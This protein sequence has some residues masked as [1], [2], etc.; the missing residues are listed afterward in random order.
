MCARSHKQVPNAG[1]LICMHLV[2]E[3][4]NQTNHANTKTREER[5]SITIKRVVASLQ[6]RA[7]LHGG[8]PTLHF[9][10]QFQ[11]MSFH[12]MD[13]YDIKKQKQIEAISTYMVILFLKT[14]SFGVCGFGKVIFY[15]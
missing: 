12:S 13:M 5:A 15:S 4:T 11:S 14:P 7:W 8:D 6:K 1:W 3:F 10:D 9:R 2:G